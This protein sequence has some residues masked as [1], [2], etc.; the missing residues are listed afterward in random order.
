MTCFSG[1]Y[2][3]AADISE[4]LTF[5]PDSTQVVSGGAADTSVTIGRMVNAPATQPTEYVKVK[6]YSSLD[7][8]R[9]HYIMPQ[10]IKNLYGLGVFTPDEFER[11][12]ANL[13]EHVNEQERREMEFKMMV[14]IG[15]NDAVDMMSRLLGTKV[16]QID[17][18]LGPYE[19]KLTVTSASGGFRGILADSARLSPST[20]LKPKKPEGGT[21][22]IP[23]FWI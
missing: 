1:S 19:D 20:V 15:K 23:S 17:L 11:M 3:V 2:N 8:A 21:V 16:C 4:W 14:G 9:G 10:A 18:D 7:V 13:V 5:N 12:C 6:P 22:R